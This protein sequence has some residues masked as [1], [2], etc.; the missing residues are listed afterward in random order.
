MIPPKLLNAGLLRREGQGFALRDNQLFAQWLPLTSATLA[1][2]YVKKGAGADDKKLG[3]STF[4][5]FRKGKVLRPDLVRT[6]LNLMDRYD[7]GWN[8]L[9]SLGDGP[10]DDD[11]GTHAIIRDFLSGTWIEFHP[12]RQG[13]R[14]LYTKG[15]IVINGP[16]DCY[17]YADSPRIIN[18]DRLQFSGSYTVCAK[19]IFFRF[20]CKD[21]EDRVVFRFPFSYLES[22][23]INTLKGLCT[24]LSFDGR[25]F[26][27]KSVLRRAPIQEFQP[28]D[29]ARV[30]VFPDDRA[31]FAELGDLNEYYEVGPYFTVLRPNWWATFDLVSTVRSLQPG[32]KVRVLSSYISDNHNFRLALE[33]IQE[34]NIN[35]EFQFLFL[36]PESPLFETRFKLLGPH[37]EKASNKNVLT[38]KSLMKK[39]VAYLEGLNSENL[40]ISIKYSEQWPVGMGFMFGDQVL[41]LGLMFAN[42]IATKGPMIEVRDPTSFLWKT[43][44]KDF[45]TAWSP[46]SPSQCKARGMTRDVDRI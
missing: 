7:Q 28:A 30:P 19:S 10:S 39:Q 17:Y 31:I 13:Q 22:E 6:A 12:S 35:V 20:T 41:Y 44:L 32:S 42:E 36:N 25:P 33:Q 3:E 14:P 43:F 15:I 2:F 4:K 46:E 27:S 38:H 8:K 24:G 37:D 16:T 5:N 29:K 1:D 21:H 18:G 11:D 9:M 26:S 40:K 34:E 23:G 45:V